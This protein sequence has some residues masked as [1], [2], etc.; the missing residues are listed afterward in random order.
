L[1][2]F[3]FMSLFHSTIS[4]GHPSNKSSTVLPMLPLGLL[5]WLW[6]HQRWPDIGRH[7]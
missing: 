5:V 7:A 2:G 6:L 1:F 4:D 3:A